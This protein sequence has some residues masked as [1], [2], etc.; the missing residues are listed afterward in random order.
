MKEKVITISTKFPLLLRK[1][2]KVVEIRKVGVP[3]LPSVFESPAILCRDDL[4]SHNGALQC[5]RVLD[6][7]ILYFLSDG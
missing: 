3:A 4:L 6:F 1:N 7:Y 5:R 2:Q